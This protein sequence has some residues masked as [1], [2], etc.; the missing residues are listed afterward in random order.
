MFKKIVK[1]IW[2]NIK[3]VLA[4]ALIVGTFYY[5]YLYLSKV[6]ITE[7]AYYNESFHNMP[8][9]SIDILVLGS[10]HAQYSFVPSFAYQDSGLYSYVLGSACQAPKVSYEML[11]EALKTQSPELVILEVYTA[12]PLSVNCEGD[13]CFVLAQYQMRGQ[14]KQNVINYLPEDKAETYRNEFLSNHNDW[15]TMEDLEKFKF[16]EEIDPQLGYITL[17][18]N[19]PPFNS[20]YPLMY[21]DLPEFSLEQE[22]IDGLNDVLNLCKENNIELLL[23]MMPMDGITAE[24]Q[25][26]LNEV[27]KWAD[28]NNLKYVDFIELSRSIDYRLRVHNDGA[29]SFSNGASVITDYLMNFVKDN[30]TFK[31]HQDDEELDEIYKRAIPGLTYSVFISEYNPI[32]YLNRLNNYPDTYVVSYN[33]YDHYLWG[34]LKDTM[35]NMGLEGFNVDDNYYAVVNNGKV[36]AY[37]YD[38]LELDFDGHHFEL[39]DKGY[40]FDNEWVYSYD[41]LSFMIYYDDYQSNFI[42]LIDT[43]SIWDIGYYYT[44]KP[45]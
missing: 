28:E 3:I 35:I 13:V 25:A 2:N 26:A 36:V 42:K 24:N 12:T 7:D 5:S 14:E 38:A 40:Y 16:D 45:W 32:K 34:D 15:R 21:D 31:N 23:Y 20:W 44:Y 1:G 39:S 27:W 17:Q 33:H 37:A 18:A 8:K 19:L 43:S 9:D 10:S 11:K 41:S 29:H 22:D 4:A 30:Y 6:F